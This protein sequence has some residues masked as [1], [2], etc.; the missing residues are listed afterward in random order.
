MTR[1]ALSLLLLLLY[2]GH[3][4][5]SWGPWQAS[6]EHVNTASAE[7]DALEQLVRFF[8]KNISSVDGARCP[9]YPTCS[10]YS[11]QALRK[12]GP[13]VGM[14]MTVDRL[15]RE[16]DPIERQ[17]VI[18]KWGHRRFYDPPQRNDFWW[19]TAPPDP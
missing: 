1:L 14:M 12:H 10:A 8:Q 17:E 9:M 5:G 2:S 16:S 15:Y 13:F 6:S 19:F 18:Y 7:P 11:R 4:S 3:A